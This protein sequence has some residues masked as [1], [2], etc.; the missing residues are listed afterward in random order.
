VSP[1][2]KNMPMIAIIASL[3]LAS[4]AFKRF[5]VFS[6]SELVSRGGLKPKSP[7]MPEGSPL[8]KYSK[9]MPDASQ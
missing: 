2:W 5:F 6:G 3:P 9:P 8:S 7:G 4:S 1:S